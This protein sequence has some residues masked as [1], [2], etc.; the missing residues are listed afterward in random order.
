M[1][2]FSG[3]KIVIVGLGKSGLGAAN[4]LHTLG[5]ELTVTDMAPENQLARSLKP[6]QEVGIRMELGGHRTETFTGADLIVL[7]PGVPHT[8]TPVQAA[9]TRGIPVWGE[10]ELASRF[11]EQPIIAITGTNGKTTTTGL[12]GAMLS[13]SGLTPFVG[14]NIGTPL[15]EY[16]MGQHKADLVV[17]EISS[18]Q[19]DTIDRFCPHVAVLLNITA[20]HLDRYA[21]MADYAA[22]KARIFT[23]Q[24]PNDVAVLNAGDDWIRA[25]TSRIK[26]QQVYFG[27]S[28]PG[29]GNAL[30]RH[31]KILIER[32]NGG[33]DAI[34]LGR[35]SLVGRH[36]HENIA[37][38]ALAVLAAGG[39]LE[40]I[41]SALNEY[42]GL[43]HRLELVGR[44]AGVDYYDDS[45]ATNVD[46]VVRAV[47]SFKGNLILIM[48]GRDKGGE[49]TPLAEPIREKV[50]ML[51]VIGEA[52]NKI[53][54]ALGHLT[55][56]RK[57]SAME[58]AVAIAHET[59]VPGDTVLLSPA[60]SSF[61]M[62]DSYA[63]RGDVFRRA[64][65]EIRMIVA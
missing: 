57:A 6:F 44:N 8:I 31:D 16:V 43:S 2:E 64:V 49:Y 27:D 28:S 52:A 62:F 58:E 7:S 5:A 19:L 36:N 50:K 40:G 33:F 26:S 65:S 23:N 34:D 54:K 11:I 37:A 42:A 59:A 60:C 13:R 25:V 4:F 61:D 21:G 15:I 56:T 12:I 39:H 45:K 55:E 3:K 46:A 48:G 30:I 29:A 32:T 41:Q 63:H 38:A 14:G 20:D 24:G 22:S 9:V 53:E 51:I 47:E 17:A 35:T 18:F 10:V 1:N